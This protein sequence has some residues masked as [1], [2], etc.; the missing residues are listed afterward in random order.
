MKSFLLCQYSW[1]LEILKGESRPDRYA[2]VALTSEAAY[3]MNL[4]GLDFIEPRDFALNATNWKDY[5]SH[6]RRIEALSCELDA[7]LSSTDAFFKDKD[8][9]LFHSLSYLLKIGY[10]Q[11]A[12]Y[13]DIIDTLRE[14][15][16]AED[17]ICADSDSIQVDE[18][19]LFTGTSGLVKYVLE[20]LASENKA[21]LTTQPPPAHE[22][23]CKAGKLSFGQP[24]KF[25]KRTLSS[26]V[27]S[28]L[29]SLLERFNIQEKK[30]T[31]LSVGCKELTA[32]N[33]VSPSPAVS[34]KE[35]N[36]IM[37]LSDTH[38]PW[39]FRHDYLT[40]VANSAVVR[41]LLSYKGID[42]FAPLSYS[43]GYLVTN[44]QFL[45]NCYKRTEKL[46]HAV[47][48][49]LV[50]CQSVAPLYIVNALAR[51]ICLKK[52][53]PFACWMHGGYGATWS[54]AGY[55]VTD[56]RDSE[57]H[58]AYGP[59]IH[60]LIYGD[61]CVLQ[62]LDIP[63]PTKIISCGSPFFQKLYNNYKRPSNEIKKIVFC[64]GIQYHKNQFYFGYNRNGAEL[65]IWSENIAI[66]KTLLEFQNTYDII[67]KDYPGS[68]DAALWPET[69]KSIGASNIRYITSEEGFDSC[70]KKADALIFP[71]VSTTFFQTLFVD[72]DKLIL[73]TGDISP[74]S[75]E[76]L[77]EKAVF[78]NE[79][80]AFCVKLKNYLSRGQFYTQ[81]QSALRAYFLNGSESVS[82][83]TLL[84]AFCPARK[85]E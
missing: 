13:I 14:K 75:H 4:R 55:D 70:A 68:E 64:L 46:I 66:V 62:K 45:K 11:L 77:S 1:Q 54:L 49:N 30:D 47:N 37:L 85:G 71:W 5:P 52:N 22:A 9:K 65:N 60:D 76:I 48:P 69:L 31:I 58:I 7:I 82:L 3:A 18:Y 72:A 29:L 23:R 15:Y 41:N 57:N 42:L 17:F 80:N 39:P 61:N 10:E 63:L 74:M 83:T 59:V 8:I 24:K 84:N 78:G 44:I 67:V 79:I 21:R 2:F 25:I 33:E 56:F 16:G 19:G 51:D 53:I 40:R 34:V 38:W 26:Y 12:W 27:F 81:D 73:E 36:P 6:T 35:Y 50:V 20:Q 43:L 32:L 28:S